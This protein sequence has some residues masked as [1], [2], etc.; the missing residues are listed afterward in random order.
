MFD[1]RLK[2]IVAA[3]GLEDRIRFLGERPAD[4]IPLWFRRVSIVVSP[5]RWEGFGLVPLEAMAS[6]CA[7]VA[8]RVGAAHHV[9]AD[10]HTGYLVSP[11]NVDALVNRLAILMGDPQFTLAMGQCGRA[12]VLDHFSIER[13]AREL[14]GVYQS[15][16]NG[17]QMERR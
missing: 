2:S 12:H 17:S 7:V 14:E 9:I 13:E 4:E 15:C 5:Q 3:A 11:G 16:W 6:G 8:T 1:K 10:E